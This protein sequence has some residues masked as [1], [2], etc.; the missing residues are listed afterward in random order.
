LTD[1]EI[2]SWQRLIRV[3]SHEI[4]NSLTPII[5]LSQTLAAILEKPRGAADE[6]DV[7]EGLAVIAERA[8][9]LQSFISAYARLARLPQ[10]NK[11]LFPA[12]DLAN[13]LKPIFT[14][15]PLQIVPFPQVNV[16]GDP[17]HLEH[18]LINLIKNA[19]EANPPTAPP[20]SLSCQ[21]VDERIEFQIADNGPGIGNPDNLFVPFYTTKPEGAGIGLILCR[22]IT[23]EHRGHVSLEN[24]TD[25]PG[26]IARLLL[27]AMPEQR[28]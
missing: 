19:L 7:R 20:V 23:A 15:K 26:A 16:F 13:R 28:G 11:V 3:I 8:Q 1:Q 21:V 5:S 22:Q 2:A 12:T 14:G 6:S 25:G 18:A 27:P 4:N 24:R 17:V 9:G 10:A